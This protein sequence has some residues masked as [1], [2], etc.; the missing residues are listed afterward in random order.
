MTAYPLFEWHLVVVIVN[1]CKCNILPFEVSGGRDTKIW[2]N[3][4]SP[5]DYNIYRIFKMDSVA[6]EMVVAQWIN[7]TLNFEEFIYMIP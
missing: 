7:G 6:G 1:S 2:V 4:L 3:H 5:A